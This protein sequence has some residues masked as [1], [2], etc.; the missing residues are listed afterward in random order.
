MLEENGDDPYIHFQIA[1]TYYVE[2]NYAEAVTSFEKAIASGAD[3][4]DGYVESLIETY[5]YSL[6]ALG[7]N[8]DAMALTGFD[9]YAD[10]AD[11]RFLC[12]LILMNN[13][14]FDEAVSSFTLATK[15]SRSSVAGCDSYAAWYNCGV[16]CEVLGE[17]EKARSYYERAGSY[18]P[19][20]KGLER[21]K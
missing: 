7:R 14:C 2:K 16:I 5:G 11:Y 3:T 19:A 12:G 18:E 13:A 17:K 1:R 10:S 8:K 9:E 21:L 20:L 6:L 4:K 15:C